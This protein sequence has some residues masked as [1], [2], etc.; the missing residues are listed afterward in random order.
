LRSERVT[1]NRNLAMANSRF[2]S[3]PAPIGAGDT[4]RAATRAWRS[5]FQST[6]API[7]AGD[8][9][10]LASDACAFQF[11]STP[12]PIGAGDAPRPSPNRCHPC[13]NPHPLR[14]ERV[15]IS[16]PELFGGEK[17]QS[18]PAPIGAGDGR[19][20][21]PPAQRMVSIHTRSDRSG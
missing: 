16:K 10:F 4:R 1:N 11:Q 6:P 18:T 15:T 14:S 8:A 3:T 21:A 9:L 2:Q 12:A 5:W 17:F 7:G 19:A 20:H 13:F